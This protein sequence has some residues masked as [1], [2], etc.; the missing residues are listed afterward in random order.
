[1]NDKTCRYSIK[2][3]WSLSNIKFVSKF[4][5]SVSTVTLEH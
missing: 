3:I 5:S 1:M 4:D 2:L